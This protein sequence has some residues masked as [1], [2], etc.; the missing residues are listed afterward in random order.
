M[1]VSWKHAPGDW[2]L[3]RWQWLY[4]PS[5]YWRHRRC[6]TCGWLRIPQAQD[7]ET[8]G[9]LA[10][11]PRIDASTGRRSK[12]LEVNRDET[13]W[14]GVPHMKTLGADPTTEPSPLWS[15]TV[16]NGG[17]GIHQARCPRSSSRGPCS[18]RIDMKCLLNVFFSYLSGEPRKRSEVNRA[19]TS[20]AGVA[21]TPESL[22][23]EVHRSDNPL[24]HRAQGLRGT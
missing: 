1:R 16:G 18:A 13:L 4:K 20:A 14:F 2:R 22:A 24:G 21:K 7:L 3:Q 6:T 19:K 12:R 9:Q 10:A 23:S 11:P 8:T 17:V 5:Q 15:A